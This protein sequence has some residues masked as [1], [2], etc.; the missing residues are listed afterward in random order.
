MNLGITGHRPHKLGG[1]N[2]YT[3]LCWPLQ[4]KMESFFVEKNPSR[5]ISGMA[6]GTDQW[7]V[8]TALRLGIEVTALIPCKNQEQL[9]PT[10][11]QIEYW[12]LLKDIAASRGGE[13]R[14]VSDKPYDKWCMHNRNREI[15]ENSSEMLAVWDGTRGG[16]RDCVRLAK[17]EGLA[18]TILHPQTLEFSRIG[19]EEV[20]E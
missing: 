16:T 9:W 10:S 14:Y 1:Y 19:T 12:R 15:V 8:A 13:V 11:A 2:E 18:I 6:L 4:D 7:A 5:I 17:S 20:Q 3:N